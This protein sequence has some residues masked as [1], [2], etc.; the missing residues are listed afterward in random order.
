M[1]TD[2][3]SCF[4]GRLKIA[5]PFLSSQT[6]EKAHKAIFLGLPFSLS[7]FGSAC[8]TLPVSGYCLARTG[9]F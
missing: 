2:V 6:K 1:M 7:A 8:R 9:I 3:F 5:H 4:G